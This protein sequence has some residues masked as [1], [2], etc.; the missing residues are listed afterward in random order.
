MQKSVVVAVNYVVWVPKYG[1]YEKR[2]GR[3]MVCHAEGVLFYYFKCKNA[4]S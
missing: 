1:V 2:V 4:W 3:H